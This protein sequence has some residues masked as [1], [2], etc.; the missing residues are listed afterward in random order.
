MKKQEL[1][2]PI[3][4]LPGGDQQPIASGVFRD[5]VRMDPERQRSCEPA[6]ELVDIGQLAAVIQQHILAEREAGRQFL[7]DVLAELLAEEQIK[8]GELER[9]L[10]DIERR[11]SLEE[12]FHELE[13]RLDARQQARDEAKRG[14]A[15]APVFGFGN[16]ESDMLG[17][18]TRATVANP[19]PFQMC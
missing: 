15:G 5:P 18:D 14:P 17:F 4:N 12:R 1:D 9:R 16:S 19:R 10:N 7:Y 11:S 6:Q 2:D 8:V 3:S 13:L